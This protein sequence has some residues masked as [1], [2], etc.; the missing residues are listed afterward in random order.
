MTGLY[1]EVCRVVRE[2][3]DDLVWKPITP[4]SMVPVRAVIEDD[5]SDL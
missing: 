3:D 4:F 2:P 1:K 5:L